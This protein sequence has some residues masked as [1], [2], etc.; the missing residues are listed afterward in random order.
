MRPVSFCLDHGLTTEICD[1]L[2]DIP[3]SC[4]L[5]LKRFRQLAQHY[6]VIGDVRGP[7]LFIGVDF[8][9]DRHRTHARNCRRYGCF[10]SA[11]G[12]SAPKCNRR[13]GGYR[14]PEKSECLTRPSLGRPISKLLLCWWT[15]TSW[16]ETRKP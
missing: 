15:S 11:Q 2:I 10:H 6:D 1:F 13:A 12:G 9:E 7:G 3:L 14:L 8:V 16:S 4:A 5:K